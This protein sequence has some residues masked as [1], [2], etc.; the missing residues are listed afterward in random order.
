MVVGG[1]VGE[2][3]SIRTETFDRC[4]CVPSVHKGFGRHRS[5][6]SR[7][8]C[9][10]CEPGEFVRESLHAARTPGK[11]KKQQRKWGP[12]RH[13]GRAGA[14]GR[15]WRADVQ[16]KAWCRNAEVVGQEGWWRGVREAKEADAGRCLREERESRQ[17]LKMEGE[18]GRGGDEEKGRA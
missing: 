12:S 16:D 18:A 4:R 6:S 14:E 17:L 7:F 11:P 10:A 9:G 2:N 13:P 8:S 3:G 15:T 1:G 5:A